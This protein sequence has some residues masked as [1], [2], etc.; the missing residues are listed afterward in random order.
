M[1]PPS[2]Q[3]WFLRD[4]IVL[5]ALA[6]LIGIA[7]RTTRR[8]LLTTTL[9][10]TAW[11]FNWQVFPL[12][13]SWHL[14]QMETLFF[15]TLGCIGVRH[16]DQINALSHWP[17]STGTGLAILWFGLVAA[18]VGLRADFDIWY[19]VDYGMIDLVV[20]QASILVGCVALF[21]LATRINSQRLVRWSGVSFFVFLVHEY[22]MRAV[23]KM[24][25]QRVMDP[26]LACWVIFPA[27]VVL[28]YWIGIWA[29]D[30]CPGAF[31]ILTG[32]RTATRASRISGDRNAETVRGS[33]TDRSTA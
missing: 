27:V 17:V 24:T 6:P 5:I 19:R 22:P 13:A 14:V 26:S 21:W 23:V 8:A 3:L 2:E 4:L 28:C 29:G 15:F 16:S 30:R 31:A 18:R 25:A 11:L 32:G 12:V 7:T 1:R 10:G 9:I 20:H 33:A